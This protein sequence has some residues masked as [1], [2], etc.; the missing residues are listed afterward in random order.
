MLWMFLLGLV[1]G[2]RAMTAMAVVCWFA[3]EGRLPMHGWAFWAAYLASVIVFTLFAL[4][5]Y[6]GDTLPK[7]PNRTAPGP[8]VSRLL[9]GAV[10]G[11]LAA[12]AMHQPAAGGIIL[13]LLGAAVGTWGG[14]RVRAWLARVMGHDLPA[15]LLES[16]LAIALAAWAAREL[17]LDAAHDR[18]WW[19]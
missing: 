10:V 8:A 13:G 19:G 7:T 1:T 4:G 14:F 11:A 12:N 16:A 5:E 3:Y 15:A 6:V 17:A 2:M 9:F 18:A